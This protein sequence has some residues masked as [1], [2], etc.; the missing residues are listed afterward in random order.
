MKL[1][2]YMSLPTIILSFIAAGISV[3]SVYELYMVGAYGDDA[4]LRYQLQSDLSELRSASRSLQR[5]ML[6]L[7]LDTTD[8]RASALA[9]FSNGTEAMEKL[10]QSADVQITAIEVGTDK[11]FV[12]T[13]KR[14]LEALIIT[15]DMVVK[16]ETEKAR[17]YFRE[18]V[19]AREMAASEY[20]DRMIEAAT[21]DASKYR[22]IAKQTKSDAAIGLGARCLVGI[23]GGLSLSFWIS[24]RK[25]IGP[26]LD[27]SSIMTRLAGHELTVEIPGL[28]RKDEIGSMALAVQFFKDSL[29]EADRLSSEQAANH[30]KAR[31][32]AE[33]IEHLIDA[34][35]ISSSG[36]LQTVTSSVSTLDAT[37]RSMTAIAEQTTTQA[38][39][40]ATAAEQTSA[41]VQ[42]VAAAAEEMAGSINELSIQIGRSAQIAGQAVTEAART[43]KTVCGLA[44]AVQKIGDV[45]KLITSI[46]SQTNLLALNATIEAARAGES[47][48]GFAVVAGE[49]KNLA[50]QTAKATEEISSQITAIQDATGGAV[51]A[52]NGIE[53]TII[54]INDISA[55]IAAAIEQ[56]GATTSEISRN[57]QQAATGTIEVS[58]GIGQV[59]QIVGDTG[60]AAGQVGRAAADLSSQAARLRTDVERFLTAIKK[61]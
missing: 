29:I 25:V 48:K 26:L 49:V 50:S 34:F 61:A 44:D 17:T 51:E 53:R 22:E 9:K 57:I 31:H 42:T 32:R 11:A 47:G 39:V 56:Q 40:V 1:S 13:Q 41:N 21:V 23:I 20:I 59:T 15:R 12:A 19:R 3:F 16:G 5:D 55:G 38:E 18:E 30:A 36:V 6:T 28:R 2:F 37:A 45:V 60:A 58:T 33:E 35:D 10:I 43:N 7:T 4:I 52:I 14:V 27:I 46:A 8:Q 54:Q 24:R